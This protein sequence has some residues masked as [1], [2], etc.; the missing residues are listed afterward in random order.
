MQRQHPAGGDLEA[1]RS[2]RSGSRCGSAGRAARGPGRPATRRT[3]SKA[4]PPV[5][6]KP[7]FWSSCAVAMYSCV[8]ASTP[9]VTRTITRAVRPSS[10]VIAA[11][12]S[13]SS[14]E[15]TT[16]RPTP[17]STARASSAHGL[18]VAVEADP[19][20]VEAG[21]QRDGQLAAGADV[22]AEPLL[23]D[24]AGDRGAEERLAG[25]EDVVRRERVAEGPGPGPE[26]G[27]VED[28][29]RG[30]VLGDQVGER[31]SRRRSARRRPCAR[32]VDQSCGTS[33]L[34]SAGWRSQAGPR[35]APGACAQPASWVIAV[36]SARARR[37]RAGRGRWRARCGWPRPAPAGPGAGRSAPRRPSAAPGS[38]S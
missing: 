38:L 15:S 18:V 24:P 2:R 1:R 35:R 23:G 33:A 25:V 6:E 16:I 13:I 3:A 30:A 36:T 7:N 12:R 34:G 5:I 27:L 4:S 20:R 32:S 10:A 11:S 31:H 28:V 26:V 14:N 22:E 9:A 17:A 37:R 21:P 29:R 8:C 19:G